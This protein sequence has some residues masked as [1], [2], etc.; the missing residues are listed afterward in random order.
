MVF[1]IKLDSS[2]NQQQISVVSPIK[3][4]GAFYS[5]V[6]D[7][8][9]NC[10]SFNF[11][12]SYSESPFTGFKKPL[13]SYWIS[14]ITAIIKQKCDSSNQEPSMEEYIY[15]IEIESI[16]YEFL[17]TRVPITVMGDLYFHFI[18]KLYDKYKRA[19]SELC[20]RLSAEISLNKIN[21]KCIS[22]ISHDFRTPLSIIYANLQL[23]EHHAFQLDQETIEDAFSLSRM[24]VKSL[25]R[26]LDKVTI[27]DSINKD[28]LEYK[29][30]KVELPV[31]CGS[32]VKELNDTEVIPD[33]VK[34]IHDPLIK[35]IEIDEYLFINL[36]THLIHNALNYSK[37]DHKVI[38]ESQYI[39]SDIIRFIIKDDGI[40]ISPTQ[41]SNINRFFSGDHVNLLEGVGLGLAIVKVCLVLQKGSLQITSEVGKG[42]IFTVDL[43][44]N[45]ES[46]KIFQ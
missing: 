29:P 13:P 14:V 11:S 33:R 42:S 19:S 34:Y 7:L 15:T 10:L 8:K 26:I 20:D 4:E 44:I 24:A 46:K 39:N 31:L 27:V 18:V 5:L 40:G 45:A 43:P 22:S 16:A 12:N 35:G 38:F 28:R 17:I 32:L 3:T 21:S 23:L 25:L 36:F 2:M 1:D 9:G 30:S 37:K 6:K 41:I